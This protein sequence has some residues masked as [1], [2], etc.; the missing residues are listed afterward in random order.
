[1]LIRS[2][3]EHKD[4]FEVKGIRMRVLLARE[5]TE[6]S[7]VIVEDYPAGV[8][9]PLNRHEEMEQIYYIISGRGKFTNGTEQREVSEGDIV[10]IPRNTDHGIA[11]VGREPLRYLCFDAFPKGYPAG[12]ETWAGHEKTIARKFGLKR[13]T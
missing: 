2:A 10:L 5:E 11:N 13:K 3:K 8:S 4:E 9:F 12:E 1:M 7:E 6:C